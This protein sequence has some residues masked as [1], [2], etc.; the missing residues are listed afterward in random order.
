[1]FYSSGFFNIVILL[2]LSLDHGSIRGLT[3]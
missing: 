3:G 1:M 2:E